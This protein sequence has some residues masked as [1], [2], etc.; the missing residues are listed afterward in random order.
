MT[1]RISFRAEPRTV[2][3]ANSSVKPN[4]LYQMVSYIL[5]ISNLDVRPDTDPTILQYRIRIRPYFKNRIRIR[6]YYGNWIRLRNP[7]Y[8]LNHIIGRSLS[9]V[10]GKDYLVLIDLISAFYFFL[11]NIYIYW[12]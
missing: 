9:R 5:G 12:Y 3:H 1:F 6:P 4:Y 10:P 7:A 8:N 11:E 2:N